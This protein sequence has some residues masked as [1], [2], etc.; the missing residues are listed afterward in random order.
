MN[1]LISSKESLKATKNICSRSSFT[2]WK[3]KHWS[4]KSEYVATLIELTVQISHKIE[5]IKTCRDISLFFEL[6]YLREK[7]QKISC[8]SVGVVKNWLLLS[9]NVACCAEI[10]NRVSLELRLIMITSGIRQDYGVLYK[11]INCSSKPLG[12]KLYWK[13]S[14]SF[15]VQTE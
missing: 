6:I 2:L 3:I 12:I 15:M 8:F 1:I 10:W 9:L 14:S 7:K 11:K 13:V 5:S 4:V